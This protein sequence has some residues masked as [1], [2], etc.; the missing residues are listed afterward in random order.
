MTPGVLNID[1]N[2]GVSFGPLVFICEDIDALPVNLTGWIPYASVRRKPGGPLVLDLAPAIT[3][4]ASG[5][6]TIFFTDEQTRIMA[7]G[8]FMWDLLFQQ[9]DGD[10]KGPFVVGRCTIS[11]LITEPL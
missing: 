5:Q 7:P 3:D 10:R 2:R 1:I 9:P 4:A 11:S 8:S 6:V